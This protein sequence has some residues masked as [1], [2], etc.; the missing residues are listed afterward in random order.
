MHPFAD[1]T[2]L[3]GAIDSL[4]G[5]EVCRGILTDWSIG[6]GSWDKI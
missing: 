6:I 1:D 5:Q 4:E 3:R 2:K